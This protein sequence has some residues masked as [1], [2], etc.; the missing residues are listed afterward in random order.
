MRLLLVE[1]DKNLGCATAQG[2]KESFAVDW[3]LSAEMADDAMATQSYDLMVL[4]IN[5][6]GRSGLDFL[7]EMRF[8][9]AQIPVLLLTARDAIRHRVEGLNA[10][11]DD[12]L[13]KPFDLDELLARCSALVRRAQGHAEPIVSVHD[14][15]FEPATGKL[16]KDGKV[17]VLSGRERAI[18]DVLIHNLDRPVSKDKIE[19]RIYDWSSEDIESNTIEVHVAALRRKLGRD[20]IKTIRGVGYMITR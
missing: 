19:Q 7:A 17:V 18:F 16:T 14:I 10:G 1:D 11:A 15:V 3:V 2:L 6:P 5:L 9:K 12:Y 20:L 8:K 4:D 13:V